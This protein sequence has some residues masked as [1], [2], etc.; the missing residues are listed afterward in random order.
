MIALTERDIERYLVDQCRAR[1][2]GCYKFT[3]PG[4]RSVPD[5]IVIV[6]PAGRPVT[7]MFFI[8]LKAPGRPPTASQCREHARLRALGCD[9]RVIDSFEEIDK[10]VENVR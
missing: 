10:F 9:V 6:P 7:Q 5:R 2:W 3:S 4:R 1:G 8:E